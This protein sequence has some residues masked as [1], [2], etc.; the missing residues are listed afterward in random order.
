MRE[1]VTERET[2]DAGS[3]EKS[4]IILVENGMRTNRSA[5]DQ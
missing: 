5:M 3:K 2:S 4:K 1:K